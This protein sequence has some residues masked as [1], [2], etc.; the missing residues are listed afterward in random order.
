MLTFL[1]VL[2]IVGTLIVLATRLSLYLYKSGALENRHTRRLRRLHPV[3]VGSLSEEVP[4]TDD[5]DYDDI[6][7]RAN[8]GRLLLVSLVVIGL[9]VIVIISIMSAVSS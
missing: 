3:A 5:A 7:R 6:S 1:I 2:I 4:A 9:V 8:F